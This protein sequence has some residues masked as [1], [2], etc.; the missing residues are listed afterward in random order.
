MARWSNRARSKPASTGSRYPTIAPICAWLR[1]AP[2]RL[3]PGARDTRRLG[4]PV[5]RIVQRDADL[6]VEAAYTHPRLCDGFHPADQ[7][8]GWTDGFARVP[9]N[10]LRAIEGAVT[11][12]LHLAPSSLAYRRNVARLDPDVDIRDILKT[13]TSNLTA[14]RES[15][16][17]SWQ[18]PFEELI[19]SNDVSSGGGAQ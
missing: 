12:E 17:I 13:T 10:L 14:T 9:N 4:V 7:G 8:Y 6:F 3:T 11:L 19:D 5:E 1:I 15:L 18:K 2:R 16:L